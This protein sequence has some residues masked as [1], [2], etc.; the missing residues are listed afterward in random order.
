MGQETGGYA[1]ISNGIRQLS[2]SGDSTDISINLPLIHGEFAISEHLKKRGITPDYWIENSIHD[3]L[4][5]KD[6]ILAFVVE[7]IKK[8]GFNESPSGLKYRT[9]REGTGEPAKAGQEVLIHETMSYYNDSLL[10]DSRKLPRPIK[11][12]IGGNQVIKGIDEGLVGM[13]K[14]E[15]KKL[16][17]PPALSKRQ[18]VQTFPHPDSTLI[19][20]IELM[21]ILLKKL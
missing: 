9:L 11:V 21:D 1:G 6:A 14:G 5:G 3:L 16:I 19:Y 15:V 20:E 7:K 13:K 12:L 4:N 8:Y 18:G 10:F 2:I 17:I